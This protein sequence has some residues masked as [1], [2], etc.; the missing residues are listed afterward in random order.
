MHIGLQCVRLLSRAA[1]L[2]VFAALVFAILHR[3]GAHPLSHGESVQATQA[4]DAMS[5]TESF[6]SGTILVTAVS[7]NEVVLAADSR[8]TLRAKDGSI[9]HTDRECKAG[10]LAPLLMYAAAGKR[11]VPAL[12]ATDV[13]WDSHGTAERAVQ[14]VLS[15]TGAPETRTVAAVAKRWE[16]LTY[17]FFTRQIS[18]GQKVLLE[19]G[20]AEAVF[21]GRDPDGRISVVRAQVRITPKRGSS[22]P[23]QD[24]SGSR[25]AT[26]TSANSGDS[27]ARAKRSSASSQSIGSFAFFSTTDVLPPCRNGAARFWED[28]EGKEVARAYLEPFVCKPTTA[29]GPGLESAVIAAV[30]R[31]ID[32][33]VRMLGT[34][35]AEVAP[36]IAAIAFDRN[37]WRWIQSGAC[38][39]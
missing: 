17:Q 37:G 18:V 11:T 34:D 5:Q 10:V 6:S 25:N 9:S 15:G 32:Q 30:Q 36:P 24:S 26:G 20:N 1:I 2:P 14:F 4:M 22:A 35:R 38:Q 13:A 27:T 39:R 31:T 19:A 29:N 3:C 16:A 23:I 8:V 33:R 28:G 7:T 21:A 12:I